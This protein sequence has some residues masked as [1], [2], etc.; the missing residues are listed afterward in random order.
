MGET[1][2]WYDRPAESWTEALP[3]GNGRIGLMDD[4]G[5]EVQTLF[6]NEDTFWSGFPRDFAWE[7]REKDSKKLW[8]LTRQGKFSQAEELARERL[9][10]PFG[11][12]YEPVGQIRIRYPGCKAGSCRRSLDMA[13]ARTEMQTGGQERKVLVSFPHQVAAL[14]VWAPAGETISMEVEL[15]AP[16]RHEIRFRQEKL[17]MLVQAP[18][19]VE[20]SYSH[21]LEEPVQYWYEPEKRGVRA[22][23]AAELRHRGG[24]LEHRQGRLCLAGAEEATLLVAIRTSFRRWDL[25]PDVPDEAL[26][27]S[28]LRD[29]QN[30]PAFA[31][32]EAEHEKDVDR[33]F[34]RV[35]LE[36]E[37]PARPELPFDRR[38]R[39][40]DPERPDLGLYELLF[41]YG[42]YLMIAGSRPGTQALTLQGIWNREVRPPWSSNY[43]LNINTQMNYWPVLSC[44]LEEMEAPLWNLT[45]ELAQAGEKTARL[46]YEAPGFVVHHNTDLWRFTWPVGNHTPGCVS[47]GF[48]PMAGAWLCCQM[49][50]RYEYLRRN[51]ELREMY[52]LLKSAGQFL[53]SQLRRESDGSLI[54]GPGTSPENNFLEAGQRHCL[55]KT[56]AVG[57]EIT[58]EL[59]EGL[60]QDTEILGEDREFGEMLRMTLEKLRRP[61]ID[62][63]G[64]LCEWSCPRQ[65]AEPEHRHISHLYAVYPGDDFLKKGREPYLQAA[66]LSLERRGDEAT[67]WSMAW[68]ACQWAR[69][70]EGDRALKLMNMQIRPAPTD[71]IQMRGGGTY[72]NGFCAHP[73]FQIDGNFGFTAAVAELLLQCREDEILLLPA[74]PGAWVGGKVCGLVAT[75]RV[76]T[77]ISWQGG[78]GEARLTTDL[79]QIRQVTPPDGK[80]QT[81]K[82]TPGK[83]MVLNW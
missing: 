70:R 55:D 58:R 29:L 40:F 53:L 17:T 73:P 47:Y 38:L 24:T 44:G 71:Q 6:L 80:P 81:L 51:E 42:R 72:P 48:F 32:L 22:C 83:E 2:L 35:N 79:A 34:D 78:H 63:E 50:K 46:L 74:L 3:L 75:G 66:R 18:S 14:H 60:A 62:P 76:R 65:E 19:L 37:G 4:G 39:E 23:V 49:A 33:F 5:E 59:L 20:P 52:P 9:T 77:E 11:E 36:L 82:L 12:S 1:K 45:R 43:T 27:E 25:A 57:L 15:D 10:F 41:Q 68:K 13:W 31:E 28:C 7:S 21:E 16:L 56:T 54:V 69:H 61:E 8:E 67:G 30:A 26:W 64:A